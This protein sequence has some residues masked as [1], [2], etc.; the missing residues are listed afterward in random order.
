MMMFSDR[1]GAEMM[2]VCAG[3]KYVEL[4]DVDDADFDGFGNHN[5]VSSTTSRE[6]R[7]VIET[8]KERLF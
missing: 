5:V 8:V 7:G 3:H 6:R 2:V 1:R 4:Q